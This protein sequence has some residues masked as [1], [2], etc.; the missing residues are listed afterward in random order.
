M[1]T[2]YIMYSRADIYK[3][4]I[5]DHLFLFPFPLK[6]TVIHYLYCTIV[7]ILYQLLHYDLNNVQRLLLWSGHTAPICHR[8]LDAGRQAAGFS[9]L[10]GGFKHVRVP[11]GH[12]APSGNNRLF[13]QL[14]FIDLQTCTPISVKHIHLY[15]YKHK[16]KLKQ[17]QEM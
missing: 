10:P 7:C 16:I 5:V 9:V 15:V 2:D 17:M 6:D 8:H 14:I 12:S 11:P 13:P 4:E 3:S 1:W